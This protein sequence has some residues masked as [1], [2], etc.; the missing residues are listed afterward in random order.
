MFWI[1]CFCLEIKARFR[2]PLPFS[3]ASFQPPYQPCTSVFHR[4]TN[5]EDRQRRTKKL[6]AKLVHPVKASCSFQVRKL[7]WKML[8]IQKRK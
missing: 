4:E 2:Q 7:D 3:D 5:V 6:I 8:V 1:S